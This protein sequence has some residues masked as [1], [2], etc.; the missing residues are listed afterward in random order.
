M[1]KKKARWPKG[2]TH[3]LS[4]GEPWAQAHTSKIFKLKC[5]ITYKIYGKLYGEG[6]HEETWKAAKQ[7]H[8]VYKVPN[9]HFIVM[10]EFICFTFPT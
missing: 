4:S 9:S 3:D 10:F 8:G 7:F 5:K 2:L 1:V 6:K